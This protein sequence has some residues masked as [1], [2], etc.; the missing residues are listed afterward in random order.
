MTKNF[1][2]QYITAP[3]SVNNVLDLFLTNDPNLVLHTEV[4]DTKISDHNII[5]ITTTP[6]S[7]SQDAQKADKNVH[8][9]TNLNLHKADF[10]LI[11]RHLESVDWEELKSLCS[12]DDFSELFRLTILQICELYS[13]VKETK[14]IRHH[15]QRR[16]LRRRLKKL[17]SKIKAITSKRPNSPTLITLSADQEKL[18]SDIKNS[19]IEEKRKQEEK[20]VR[21]IQENPR[22]FFS[23][24]KRSAKSK[25]RVGPL[26]DKLKKIQK[27]PKKMADLL[28]DQYSSVFS[29]AKAKTKKIPQ[30]QQ[31]S[32]TVLSDIEFSKEDIEKAMDEVKENSACGEEDI[33]AIVLKRCKKNLSHPILLI[34]K[35]SL[36]TG[37]IRHAYKKQYITPVHKKD[38]RALPENYRPISLTSHLIKIFE[39]VI[40]NVIVDHLEINHLLC[41]N[42]HGF[43]KG[44]SCLTQLL[45]HIDNIL[46]NALEGSDT[47]VIYLDFQKA[48]DKVDHEIL[49]QKLKNHGITGNLF[50]WLEEYLKNRPQIVVVEGQHSYEATVKSGV[51]QG[52]VLGPILFLIYINNLQ[53][54]I[55][56]STLSSFA[57][58][59]RIKKKINSVSDVETLQAD[60]QKAEKW[61]L[62]NNMTLHDKKFELMTHSLNK[63]N[64][65]KELPFTNEFFQYTTTN[66]VDIQPKTI[67]RDLGVNVSEDL[68]WSP[69]IHTI[70]DGARK[71]SAWTLSVFSD[72]S[73]LNM[74]TLYK[75]MIRPRV[76]YCSPLWHPHKI[77]DIQ[78]LENIQRSF[79]SKIEGYSNYDYH[80]RLKLLKIP[81]LQRRRERYIMIHMFKIKESICPND[82][83]IQ[84]KHSERRGIRAVIPPL[85]KNASQ[86]VQQHYDTSFAVVGPM[87]WNKIPKSTTLKS[88]LSSF[89][90]SLQQFLEAIPD[91]PPTRG[92]TIANNNSILQHSG[93]GL[94]STARWPW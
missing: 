48:F 58:D 88:T 46:H 11:N 62:I 19:I 72:R 22:F 37:F 91:E 44:R 12:Q 83:N 79:T 92:Y 54:C 17:K 35:D 55:V 84:F 13:P 7:N 66:G 28:Q 29:D 61:S 21:A 20:A 15:P 64:L 51:P 4:T 86:R 68:S 80:Q 27:D 43:R 36:S 67:V 81:S 34:W 76:E 30:H 69:H 9:F 38:S 8:T 77:S 90:S 33:P 47:D 85:H 10:E 52:T 53:E 63:S 73:E 31:R 60:L 39:R 78:T 25:S 82:L 59:T 45:A 49:L 56:E 2:S 5:H 16:I 87:L 40:R 42:Q 6:L 24:A 41:K 23:Y 75:M 18:H 26:F 65:T 1:L 50:N 3:T 94:Q 14:V 89:K 93:G 70:T 71:M 32:N 74:M 57:D